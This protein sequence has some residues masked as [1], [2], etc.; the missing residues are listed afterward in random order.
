MLVV[1]NRSLVLEPRTIEFCHK[2]NMRHN[3]S[4]VFRYVTL[5][6]STFNMEIA[7]IR[8]Y[9]YLYKPRILP[10]AQLQIKRQFQQK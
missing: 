2:K 1:K 3:T 5:R 7:L 9:I 6:Y 8:Q 4:N 10:H